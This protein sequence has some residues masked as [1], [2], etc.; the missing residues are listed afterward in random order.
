MVR[1]KTRSDQTDV[2]MIELGMIADSP[3]NTRLIRKG[4]RSIKELAESMKEQGQLV[5]VIVRKKPGKVL[6][7]ELLAGKR[8]LAAAKLAGL[9]ELRAEVVDVDDAAAVAITVTENLQREDLTPLQ[10]AQQL[11]VLLEQGKDTKEIAAQLGRLPSWVIRRAKLI[12][13]IPKWVKAAETKLP[14][15]NARH[16]ELIARYDKNKQRKL[17]DE[18]VGGVA[19]RHQETNIMTVTEL[20]ERLNRDSDQLKS[21]QWKL[22]DP[23]LLPHVGACTTCEKRSGRQPELFSDDPE[24]FDAQK[25]DRCLDLKCWSEKEQAYLAH[26][27]DEL[28]AKHPDLIKIANECYCDDPK[29]LS[30]YQWEGCLKRFVG[31]KPAVVVMGIGVGTLP[32]PMPITTTAGLVMGIGVGTLRYVRVRSTAHS[33]GSTKREKGTPMTMEEKQ[34]RLQGRRDAHVLTWLREHIHEHPPKVSHRSV[35]ANLLLHMVAMFGAKQGCPAEDDRRTTWSYAK[36]WEFIMEFR[37]HNTMRKDPIE[38]VWSR[39]HPILTERLMF[40]DVAGASRQ[41]PEAKHICQLLPIDFDELVRKAKDA[42]PTPKSWSAKPTAKKRP[43]KKTAAMARETKKAT[44]TKTTRKSKK[45]K[46]S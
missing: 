41:L 8:R 6:G 24:K 35:L 12:D 45:G 11:K 14:A 9:T 30:S 46:R 21:A 10:E 43:T 2:R 27:M 29:I 22:D 33:G 15:W 7:Y 23:T 26:R 3:H 37:A 17:Y 19:W 39:V 34:A 40:G 42:I 32:T 38:F 20:A 25:D 18:L 16:L 1:S 44:K 31:S 13:L 4:D 36:Q 5:P 28:K